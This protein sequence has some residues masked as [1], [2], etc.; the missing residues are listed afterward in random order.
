MSAARLSPAE[1]HN[2]LYAKPYATLE[3]DQLW[4]GRREVWTASHGRATRYHVMVADGT[5]ACRPN[6]NSWRS[7]GVILL[8]TDTL[9]PIGEVPAYMACLRNGCRQL[10]VAAIA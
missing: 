4:A 7:Q 1:L 5:A 10:F 9:I 8:C 3:V 2:G 6:A